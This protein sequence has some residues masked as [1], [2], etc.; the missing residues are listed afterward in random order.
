MKFLLKLII[1]HIILVVVL[2]TP[3]KIYG[4][5]YEVRV[6][7]NLDGTK[8]FDEIPNGVGTLYT[9]ELH[10]WE[11]TPEAIPALWEPYMSQLK[12]VGINEAPIK[13]RDNLKAMQAL[14]GQYQREQ[15]RAQVLAMNTT[16]TDIETENLRQGGE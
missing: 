4:Q 3:S 12:A 6:T 5:Y 16:Q 7:I 1:P 9:M 8:M 13:T 10:H 15:Q 2:F 11:I 14:W